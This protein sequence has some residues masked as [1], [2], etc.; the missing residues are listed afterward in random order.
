MTNPTYPPCLEVG[1]SIPLYPPSFHYQP[2]T[3][4]FPIIMS[5]CPQ[6]RTITTIT[7]TLKG[8]RAE[9]L[10][11]V[12]SRWSGWIIWWV[13]LHRVEKLKEQLKSRTPLVRYSKENKQ[14]KMVHEKGNLIIINH[15]TEQWARLPK[16]KQCKH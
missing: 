10:S 8:R 4:V 14:T 7:K 6:K 15:Q 16:S 2:K 13:W 3:W 1:C 11:K 12:L 5:W 9:D